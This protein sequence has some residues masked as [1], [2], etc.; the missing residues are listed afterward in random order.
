M[1]ISGLTHERER[2]ALFP[3]VESRRDEGPQLVEPHR[4]GH[5]EADHEGD[6]QLHE[7]R[8]EDPGDHKRVPVR[9]EAA[10]RVLD[11]DPAVRA[12]DEVEGPF[13]QEPADDHARDDGEDGLD[14]PVAEFP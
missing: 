4:R 6:L 7:E 13:V 2:P 11:G 5:D 1:V 10:R 8:V 12:D 3:L 14:Q 9:A